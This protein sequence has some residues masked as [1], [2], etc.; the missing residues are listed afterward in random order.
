[1]ERP[2]LGMVVPMPFN[3][4]FL[5]TLWTVLTQILSCTDMWLTDIPNFLRVT[6]VPRIYSVRRLLRRMLPVNEQKFCDNPVRETMIYSPRGQWDVVCKHTR[7][8]TK[9]CMLL[10]CMHTEWNKKTSKLLIGVCTILCSIWDPFSSNEWKLHGTLPKWHWSYRYYITVRKQTCP[11]NVLR[12]WATYFFL[13]ALNWR[14]WDYIEF[15]NMFF[16]HRM[17]RLAWVMLRYL[18]CS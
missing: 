13:S 2:L 11:L 15:F 8:T 17:F 9:T 5:Q 6:I 12:F 16:T 4:K 18:V 3:L 1:M 14:F 10:T 7:S